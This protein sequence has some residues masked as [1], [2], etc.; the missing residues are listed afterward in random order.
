LGDLAGSDEVN[1]LIWFA[2]GY[3][4]VRK[5]EEGVVLHILKFGK[6]NL[7]EDE[8]LYPFSYHVYRTNPAVQVEPYEV[9]TTS[10]LADLAA[11]LWDRIQGEHDSE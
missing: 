3:Y 11:R 6:L 8:E 5:H 9:P 7:L 1:R 10:R 2:D 4:A